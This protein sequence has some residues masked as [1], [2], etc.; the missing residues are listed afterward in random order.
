MSGSSTLRP[1]R[2]SLLVLTLALLG[3]G[4]ALVRAD[5]FLEQQRRRNEI[6][7][8]KL[9]Q[10]IALAL[11]EARKL[12]KSDPIQAERVL[13]R[14]RQQVEDDR[15]LS[16]QRRAEL[17]RQLN[18]RLRDVQAL[19]RQQQ[20]AEARTTVTSG[21]KT[22]EPVNNEGKATA[23]KVDDFI[24]G[25]K[26]YLD[27]MARL[28]S[29][30]ERGV[31]GILRD[32]DKSAVPVDGYVEFP[33]YWKELNLARKKFS[34]PQLTEREAKLLKALNSV[35]SVDFDKTAFRDVLD[36]IREKAEIN[37][38]V[39]ENSLK[40]AQ[41]EYDDPVNLK[42]KKVTVRTILKKVLGD[43]NLTYIIREGMVEVMT[44][45]KAREQ[46]TVRVYPLGDLIPPIDPRLGPFFGRAQ[47]LQHVAAIIQ[48]IQ[49]T[50]EPGSWQANGGPGT[51]T[52]N[53]ASMSLVI[54][55]SAEMHYML[56]QLFAGG[57]R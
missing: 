42:V 3:G 22:T 45:Q 7:A 19:V 32:I 31:V 51:I 1:R 53:E 36:Y 14:C 29:D 33:K 44:P 38:L 9:E 48:L 52:F 5:D 18:L 56:P 13:R 10:E 41:V 6:A 40:E 15:V 49:N 54:R 23:Q 26:T 34:G 30:R 47:M 2:L 25:G 37:I 12:E 46:M 57:G 43:R 20:D 11:A 17:L 35:M 24:K 21:K 16:D 4:A 28:K 27:Q 55:N 39:D 50:I 8:Q